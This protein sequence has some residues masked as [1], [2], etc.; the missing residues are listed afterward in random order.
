MVCDGRRGTRR[1]LGLAAA[2][3]VCLLLAAGGSASGAPA[4]CTSGELHATF[5]LVPGSQGAGQIGYVLTITNGGRAAC[6]L[7]GVGAFRLLSSTGGALPTN[8]RTDP[9]GAYTVTLAAGQWVQAAAS[10]TPD[11]AGPGEPGNHC[12]PVAHALRLTLADA[13]GTVT[14]PMDPTMVCQHGRIAISRLKAVPKE[15]PCKVGALASAFKAVGPPYSGQVT[16][17]LTLTNTSAHACAVIGT[18]GLSLRSATGHV[19]PTGVAA[20]V[21]YPYVIARR[22]TATLDATALT[23]AGP[24]EPVSGACE[25]PASE[26]K[27][28]LP[29]GGGTIS[30]ALRPARSLCHHGQ[31]A[32]SG[33]FQNG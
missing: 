31:L 18:P 4:G 22:R 33:L 8:V 1:L 16:Y 6:A 27:V 17:A 32:V 24:G 10:F 15:S 2:A 13:R 19:L 14:A 26:L 30:T 7:R 23:T 20:P 9:G 21:P 12:E 5:A 29:L 28:T 25:P 3:G 11:I